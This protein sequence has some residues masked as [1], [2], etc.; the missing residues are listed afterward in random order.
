M[1]LE[2]AGHSDARTG[3]LE[4]LVT[5]DALGVLLEHEVQQAVDR[6]LLDDLRVEAEDQDTFFATALHGR[7]NVEVEG[8]HLDV[9]E[10]PVV[11]HAE[12]GVHRLHDA[13]RRRVAG[14][15]E[16]D[17]D[18]ESRHI[19]GANR[20]HLLSFRCIGQNKLT[21]AQYVSLENIDKMRINF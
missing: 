5:L 7:G 1:E 18:S 8:G 17:D 4:L 9:P 12:V 15:L 13:T 21:I 2:L 6:L 10:D 3:L 20:R 11:D 14:W 19:Q 16:D